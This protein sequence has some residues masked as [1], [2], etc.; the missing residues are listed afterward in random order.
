MVS[1][2]S[3]SNPIQSTM[4]YR[5]IQEIRFFRPFFIARSNGASNAGLNCKISF[6][7]WANTKYE[8]ANARVK[9]LEG[10]AVLWC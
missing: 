7:T 5:L 3:I 4:T 10:F 2:K 1:N 9:G 6:R 8:S